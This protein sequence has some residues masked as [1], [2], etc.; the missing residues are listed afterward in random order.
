MGAVGGGGGIAL[1]SARDAAAAS[2]SPSCG[3]DGAASAGIVPAPAPAA[4]AA[5]APVG[6]PTLGA[7]EILTAGDG[8]LEGGII[9]TLRARSRDSETL[10]PAVAASDST[11]SSSSSLSS[12]ETSAAPENSG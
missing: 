2:F 8:T 5:G 6:P 4:T 7:G 11:S 3:R 9:E 1:R 12:S 10:L